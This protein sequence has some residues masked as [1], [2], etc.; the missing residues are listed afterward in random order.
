MEALMN[1][2]FVALLKREYVEHRNGYL[3]IPA[4]LFGFAL[5]AFAIQLMGFGELDFDDLH[6]N[7]SENLGAAMKRAVAEAPEGEV[8]AGVSMIYWSTSAFAMIALPFILFFSLLGSLYE[9]RRDRSILFWKSLPVS[10]TQ[11]VLAKV[12][13]GLVIF[14]L[15]FTVLAAVSQL[16]MAFLVS[17][18]VMAQ[19]GPVMAMWPLFSMIDGWISF[20]LYFLLMMAWISPLLAWLMLVS[21]YA[22]RMPFVFAVLPIAALVIG[23]RIFMSSS[24]LIQWI[25]GRFVGFAQHLNNVNVHGPKDIKSIIGLN[26]LPDALGSALS[27]GQFWIGLVM[28]AAFLWGAIEL[29]RQAN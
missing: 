23:E 28:A 7:S 13:S 8:A 6:I 14:P 19:G 15:I 11:E 21:A 26:G 27:S 9:E 20:Y 5:I 12:V 25:V 18:F 4:I 10:D 22:P 29:R 17:I 2:K 16:I 24:N 1:H 3:I